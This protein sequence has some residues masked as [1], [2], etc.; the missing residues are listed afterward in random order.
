MMNSLHAKILVIDDKDSNRKLLE[1]FVQAD[2]Y[3]TVAATDGE[4]GIAMAIS[5]QPN[6]ILLDLMM[7]GLDGFEVVRRL[8]SNP[9][10]ASIPVIVVTA[11]YDIASRQ[12]LGVWGSTEILRKPVDRWELSDR[13]SKLLA[14]SKD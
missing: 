14:S 12:R 5:E 1:V 8:K 9:E 10:T 7:P 11:L 6:V 3:Q 13:I 4:T 2:G